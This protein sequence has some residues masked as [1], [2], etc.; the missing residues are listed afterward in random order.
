MC[1]MQS[2]VTCRGAGEVSVHV[3]KGREE[4]LIGCF[5]IGEVQ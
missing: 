3:E 2:S 1:E 5:Y 4:E